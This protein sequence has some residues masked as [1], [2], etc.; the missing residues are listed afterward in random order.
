M[1]RSTSVAMRRLL[2]LAGFLVFLAGFQLFVLT[3][4][5]DSYFAWTIQ[6]PMTA[7]F[8]GGG[9]FASFLLEF[10]ASREKEWARARIAVPAV[11]VFTTLT[12]IAT[13]LHVDRF[14]FN[15]PIAIA[16]FAAWFWLAI[17]ALVPPAM[18][19]IWIRQRR[20]AGED[21]SRTAPLSIVIRVVVA[22]Q[23]VLMLAI[24]FGLFLAPS[25]TAPFWPWKLTA[26]TSRAV[27]A[28]LLG[29]GIY[30]L[31]AAWENDRFRISAGLVSYFAFGLLEIVALLRYPNDI[32][33]TNPGSWGYTAFVISILAVGLIAIVKRP[34]T[35]KPT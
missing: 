14:H 18:V 9:Y 34:G 19:G 28:W 33:W 3:D 4:Y 12:L 30:A 27:G 20:M 11:F 15:S 24:G 23:A 6:P 2:L 22:M 10:L 32:D 29:V 8:L 1:I 35:H 16:R 17:Y 13:L 31:H 26:L 5:T 7:A 25:L 21:S